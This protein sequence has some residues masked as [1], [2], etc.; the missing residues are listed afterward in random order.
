MEVA[1][2]MELTLN[3]ASSYLIK[4]YHCVLIPKIFA[5]NITVQCAVRISSAHEAENIVQE[6]EGGYDSLSYSTL[7]LS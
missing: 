6:E 3:T 4:T 5:Y 7:Y 2:K 1:L